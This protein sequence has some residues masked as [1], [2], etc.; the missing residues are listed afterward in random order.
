MFFDM[1]DDLDSTDVLASLVLAP[2]SER[3]AL[4]SELARRAE[5]SHQEPS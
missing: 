1:H 4:L 2:E 5:A 3:G